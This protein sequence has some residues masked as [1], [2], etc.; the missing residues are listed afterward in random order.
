MA[1]SLVK[2]IFARIVTTVHMICKY[3]Y[4]LIQIINERTFWAL[5]DQTNVSLI[6]LLIVIISLL[7]VAGDI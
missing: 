4:L 6:T 7:R 2:A 1:I 5:Y 3:S